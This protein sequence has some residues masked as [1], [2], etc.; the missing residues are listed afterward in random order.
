MIAPGNPVVPIIPTDMSVYPGV[1]AGAAGLYA[2]YRAGKYYKKWRAKRKYYPRRKHRRFSKAV[3]KVVYETAETR[4]KY[5]LYAAT[6]PVLATSVVH[7]LTGYAEGTGDD[8]RTGDH[9]HIKSIGI[10]GTIIGNSAAT[11]DTVCRIML[12]RAE[13][14]IAG[15][16]P[17]ITQILYDDSTHAPRAW[18]ERMAFKILYNKRFILPMREAV[19]DIVMPKHLIKIY[20]RFKKCKKVTYTGDG[21]LIGDAEWGHFFLVMMTD[22]AAGKQPNWQLKWRIT[23][24][25]I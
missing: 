17:A 19:G 7:Y 22:A 6:T 23:W 11:E 5:N 18:D 16:L 2:G 13:K 10:A 25:D 9:A 15:T 24:K 20:K 4:Q 21:A 14:N 1:L 12:V 3:R 8:E